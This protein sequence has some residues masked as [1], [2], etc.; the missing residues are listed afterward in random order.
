MKN[1]KVI[2][3]KEEEKEEKESE[4]D[5]YLSIGQG[6][7]RCAVEEV[8]EEAELPVEQRTREPRN[9]RRNPITR[10][11]RPVARAIITTWRGWGGG[12]EGGGGEEGEKEEG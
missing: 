10:E 3:T 5:S 6:F 2:E 1:N 11:Q 8:T 7:M 9:P 12:G 4:A